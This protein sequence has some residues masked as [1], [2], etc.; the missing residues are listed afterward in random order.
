MGSRS[1]AGTGG[2]K[3]AAQ[4]GRARGPA[5]SKPS[6][7]KSSDGQKVVAKLDRMPTPAEIDRNPKAYDGKVYELSPDAL[8]SVKVD[9]TS[10]FDEKRVDTQVKL[11][12]EGTHY[13]ARIGYDKDGNMTIADGRHRIEAARR[14]GKSLL[15]K[16][17]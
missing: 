7:T 4:A 3:G 11:R 17:V 16:F 9:K 13:V 5:R 15:V 6:I 10:G 2:A 1:G 12:R 14:D 8:S